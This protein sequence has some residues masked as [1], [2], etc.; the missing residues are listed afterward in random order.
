VL[1]GTPRDCEK[2]KSFTRKLLT[3]FGPL[4]FNINYFKGPNLVSS[5]F[6]VAFSFLEQKLLTN[7]SPLFVFLEFC[8]FLQGPLLWSSVAR[9]ALAILGGNGA[10]RTVRGATFPRIRGRGHGQEAR[11]GISRADSAAA[12]SVFFEDSVCCP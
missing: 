12:G 6:P 1:T 11:S 10:L 7:C 9:V 3:T 5:F 4:T 8:A 2:C